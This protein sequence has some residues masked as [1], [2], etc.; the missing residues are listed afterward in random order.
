MGGGDAMED[1]LEAVDEELTTGAR[2]AGLGGQ[3]GSLQQVQGLGMP[4]QASILPS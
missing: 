3:S 2:L 1:A 4:V